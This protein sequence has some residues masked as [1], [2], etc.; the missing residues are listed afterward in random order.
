MAIEVEMFVLRVDPGS[1]TIAQAKQKCAIPI[2][3]VLLII[4]PVNSKALRDD[5]C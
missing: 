3:K 2:R 5:D 4:Q 1:Q